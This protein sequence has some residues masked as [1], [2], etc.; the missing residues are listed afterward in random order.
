MFACLWRSDVSV[1]ED[2]GQA[3]PV[4]VDV[5]ALDRQGRHPAQVVGAPHL[6][7]DLSVSVDSGDHG[8]HSYINIYIYM[9]FR[10]F[11]PRFYPKRRTST[12]V[13]RR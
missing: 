9:T 4:A 1:L 2:D 3:V 5:Q 6:R 10:A 12:F 13:R 7:G 8:I 11:S